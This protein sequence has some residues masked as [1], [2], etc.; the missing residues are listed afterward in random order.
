MNASLSRSFQL[1]N[2]DKT[3][4]LR[5]EALNF[6]NHPQFEVPGNRLSEGN[7]GQI[8]N[9]LNDGRAFRLLL[10]LTF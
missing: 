10:R 5:A 2:S 6:T 3:M 9:T 1:G 8:T 4:Y 7:F